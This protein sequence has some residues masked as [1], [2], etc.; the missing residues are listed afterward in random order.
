MDRLKRGQFVLVCLDPGAEVSHLGPR[1]FHRGGVEARIE[2][3]VDGVAVDGLLVLLP[4]FQQAAAEG[5]FQERLDRGARQ[6]LG[7]LGDVF[8]Q[9]LRD[10]EV[11]SGGRDLRVGVARM[12][13]A[14][15]KVREGLA[16]GQRREFGKLGGAALSLQTGEAAGQRGQ[17][18]RVEPASGDVL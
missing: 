5:R 12:Q 7:G 6:I 17:S 8:L 3:L 13:Q 9:R 15:R 11:R 2:H 4:D 14:V 1:L 10:L 18:L 16:A